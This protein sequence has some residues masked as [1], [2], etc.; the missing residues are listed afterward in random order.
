MKEL[1]PPEHSYVPNRKKKK[2][3][4]PCLW[5]LRGYKGTPKTGLPLSTPDLIFVQASCVPEEVS[6]EVWRVLEV[7]SPK[8][9]PILGEPSPKRIT[10]ACVLHKH[11]VQ[12]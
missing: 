4:L 6:G 3:I 1:D 7:C 12:E 11:L 8:K 9:H 2:S 10:R 5:G